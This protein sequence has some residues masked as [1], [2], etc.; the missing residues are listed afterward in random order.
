MASISQKLDALLQNAVKTGIPGVSAAIANSNGILWKSQAGEAD[1]QKHYDITK[2]NIFGVGSITKVFVAVVILQ[3]V[4]EGVFGMSD[5]PGSFLDASV[6]EGIPNAAKATISQM[7]SHT[8]GIPSWEFESRWIRDGRGVDCDPSRIWGKTD[9][10]EYIRQPADEKDPSS[11]R[12]EFPFSYSNTNFTLLGLMIEKVTGNTAESE[13][14]KRILE[15]LDMEGTYLEGFEQPQPDRLPHR[16]H[17]AT[18]T[19]RKVAGISPHFPEV[20]SG[21]IDATSSNLSVEWTAG[22]VVSS[23]KDLTRFAL[24]LRNREL[25]NEESTK[26]M[27]D[28]KPIGFPSNSSMGHGLFR[29]P[30]GPSTFLC[31]HTGSVLGFTANFSFVEDTDLAVCVCA[32]V[33]T[34]HVGEGVKGADAITADPEF[35][36]L[37]FELAKQAERF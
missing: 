18:S 33:G 11:D 7:T 15:P 30:I 5:T 32:N 23:P 2:Y 25:L 34:M 13:I 28:W 17:Y 36:K 19:F 16:Y 1:I 27:Q 14:R 29:T 35:L 6:L 8:S 24:A 3:L 9:T 22:G 26:I 37:A 4:E 20:K 21:I 12:K 10:L 31:G